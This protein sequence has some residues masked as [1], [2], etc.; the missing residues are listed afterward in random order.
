MDKVE[1][2]IEDRNNNFSVW[3]AQQAQNT[4]DPAAHQINSTNRSA[5]N[6]ESKSLKKRK[7]SKTKKNSNR[8]QI[9][10]DQNDEADFSYKSDVNI[11][12]K[13]YGE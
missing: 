5:S 1:T 13:Y 10:K 9:R 4:I 8:L 11:A 3:H 6:N 7:I 12:L 2:N